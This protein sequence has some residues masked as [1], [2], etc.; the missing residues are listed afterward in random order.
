MVIH[1]YADYRSWRL[2]PHSD[3]FEAFVAEVMASWRANG[4][5]PD[6]GLQLPAWLD[7]LGLDVRSMIALV[8]VPRPSDEVWQWPRA[9]VVSA[10]RRLAETGRISDARAREF[11]DA[12]ERVERAPF[13]FQITPTVLEIVAVRR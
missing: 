12:F 8:E 7:E 5:E 2:S 11:M 6:I 10:T 4:G 13:A 3:A 1:E 9:Y